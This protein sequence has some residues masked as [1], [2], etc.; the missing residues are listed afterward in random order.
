MTS[1]FKNS[2]SWVYL[3]LPEAY[4]IMPIGKNE[5]ICSTRAKR[6]PRGGS[7]GGF[8]MLL[9]STVSIQPFADIGGSYTCYDRN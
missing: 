5:I 1:Q 4:A 6:N 3:I 7:P 8:F 9:L 2:R